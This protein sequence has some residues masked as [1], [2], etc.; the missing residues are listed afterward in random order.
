MEFRVIASG[1]SGNAYK[2]SDGKTAL[3]LDAGIPFKEIQKALR[4]RV[5]DI[6]G[7]L[8][9]HEHNDHCMAVEDL[10]KS[11]INI[12]ASKGTYEARGFKGHRMK[13]VE[14]LKEIQ[15]GTFKVLPFGVEHDAEEPLGFLLQSEVTNEKLLYFTDTYY[16]KYR[17]T[18]LNII[19]G[20][21][22]FSKD[23]IWN[24][25]EKG[26][27]PVELVPRL[28]KSHMSID[29]FLGFIA[30]N[31]MSAVKEIHLIHL[32]SNNGNADEFREAVARAVPTAA[33]KVY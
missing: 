13:V 23:A 3:L 26:V 10:A 17:F 6:D 31:D 14:S 16:L 29:N 18:G 27:I 33:V 32:S 15:I 5:R 19:A 30:A 22:N 24:S 9:T 25:V 12:Y 21:C 2:V 1:S 11:G 28:V 20:E 7:C 4:F 8:V